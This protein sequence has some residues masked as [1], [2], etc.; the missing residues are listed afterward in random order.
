M[1]LLWKTMR[2][3]LIH[4]CIV[5]LRFDCFRISRPQ[6]WLLLL[7]D[8]LRFPLTN[9][10][11]LLV[12]Q[13]PPNWVD[14][15]LG[16]RLCRCH[17]HPLIDDGPSAACLGAPKDEGDATRVLLFQFLIRHILQVFQHVDKQRFLVF[18]IRLIGI[19]NEIYVNAFSSEFLSFWIR[20]LLLI[21]FVKVFS[22][23]L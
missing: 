14:L 12:S 3:L 23:D 20:I 16:E 1:R 5:H 4:G 13:Y 10:L 22:A 17:P 19:P 15:L 18:H 7:W 8:D 11:L 9:L 2:L 6:S 21:K